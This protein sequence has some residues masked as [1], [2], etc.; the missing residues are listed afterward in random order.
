MSLPRHNARES[1]LRGMRLL[2]GATAT[3]ALASCASYRPAPL[4]DAGG[5]SDIQHLH[6]PD[7]ADISRRL[8][9]HRFDPSD[10]LDVTEVAMLAVAN[11]P[12]LKL[13]R[14]KLGVKQ[15][16]AFAAGLLPDPQLS[17]NLDFPDSGS[18]SLTSAF[19]LGLSQ[20]LGALLTRPSRVSSANA[21][22]RQARLDLLWAEW[23]TI[24][25][26]RLLFDQIR[27]Q[28]MRQRR[29]RREL[30]TITP[31]TTRIDQA[32]TRGDL[33]YAAANTG[34]D[35]AAGIRKQ[36]GDTERQLEVDQHALRQLLGLA[37]DVDLVLVGKAWT[38][39]PTDAQI[40]RA[41]TRLVARRPDLLA[42]K[43]GYAAQEA[44]VRAAILGQFPAI[45]VGI[46][47]ARDTSA[48]YTSGFTIGITLPLFNRNRGNIAIARATRRQLADSYHERLL[49]T[50]SDV[51]RLRQALRLLGRQQP[52][53][54]RHARKLDAAATA[55]TANWR[56]G[57]LDWPTWLSIRSSA[58]NADLD[59]YDLHEQQVKAALAL[60]TLLGGDWTDLPAS[61]VPPT[62]TAQQS[63]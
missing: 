16:Q 19:G 25:H 4:T 35:A 40:N 15:A 12:Q 54:E 11:S 38:P 9:A 17:L 24:A 6:A 3:L 23:Q 63:P 20:D 28:Q 2:L 51:H 42:L 30:D 31:L 1:V 27:Y 43:A 59:R 48:V 33:D 39:Q 45:Q 37:P 62:P 10:G 47:R 44:D 36:L 56:A 7:T 46:T 58:L 49:A 26:A 18:S 50:R 52:A 60:Q 55:A 13:M 22:R 14:D 21:S 61:S 32:L 8:P 5:A 34:L 57:R 53:V 41:L 29:L